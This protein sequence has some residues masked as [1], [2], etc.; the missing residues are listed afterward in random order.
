MGYRKI[1]ADVKMAAI[2]IYEMDL[3][4][5]EDILAIV[6]FSERTWWR[7]LKRYRTTGNVEP[8][9][10]NKGGR[11]RILVRDDV[12]YLL[13]LI[14]HRPSR[15]LDELLGLLATNRFISV[16]Y[17]TIFRELERADISLKK[18]RIIAKERDED[19][20]A[21]F[22]RRIAQYSA[23][24]IGFLDEFSK[25]ERTLHRRRGRAKKGRHAAEQGAFVRGRRV[26][27]EGLLTVD[28]IV[29]NTVVE[30]SMTK[31]KFLYFLEHQ[32][33]SCNLFPCHI[34]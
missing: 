18:L 11:P 17:A 23:A 27:G 14:R 12:D 16:H 13:A 19:V 30:A 10:S 15:F 7:T 33:V 31:E 1:S 20:R 22:I 29:A 3:M 2:R 28:G 26:S 21:D 34:I 4:L 25:D 5:L 32:V 9:A 24:E 8:P 6:N